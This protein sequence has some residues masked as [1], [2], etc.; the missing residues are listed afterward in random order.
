ME[1]VGDPRDLGVIAFYV[2]V[3]GE[4]VLPFL[5]TT[6]IGANG[7]YINGTLAKLGIPRIKLA[8]RIPD[9]ENAGRPI[10]DNNSKHAIPR[11][12]FKNSNPVMME[13]FKDF[14]VIPS[15][16]ETDEAYIRE[17]KVTNGFSVNGGVTHAINRKFGVH[18][19]SGFYS[20]TDHDYHATGLV[21]GTALDY[22]PIVGLTLSISGEFLN[23]NVTYVGSN[24]AIKTEF[25]SDQEGEIDPAFA[26][27]F[28]TAQTF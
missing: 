18:V 13:R 3:G 19:N 25:E 12:A 11:T 8:Q 5:P 21:I 15:E 22:K 16:D 24:Q 2:G 14:L 4:L 9:G 28:S 26:I 10:E 6:K 20:V 17:L 23:T 1:E 27:T 7:F